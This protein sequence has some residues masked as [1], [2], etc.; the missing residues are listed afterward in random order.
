MKK[1]WLKNSLLEFRKKGLGINK[2]KLSAQLILDYSNH[3]G[4]SKE[5]LNGKLKNLFQVMALYNIFIRIKNAQF[6]IL[7]TIM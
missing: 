4:S 6:R 2:N 1:D 7:H 5:K 3:L